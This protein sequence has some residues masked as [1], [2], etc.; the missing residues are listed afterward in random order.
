MIGAVILAL[1]CVY[2]QYKFG[3]GEAPVNV[4]RYRQGV[5]LVRHGVSKTYFILAG[6]R[7]A[8]E[9]AREAVRFQ[10]VLL[11][12]DAMVSYRFRVNRAALCICALVRFQGG[13]CFTLPPMVEL[14]GSNYPCVRPF[15]RDIGNVEAW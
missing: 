4:Y 9:V 6:G 5:R 11:R 12:V 10:G 2:G 7:L 14:V 3:G 13:H 15:Q 8:K 1:F